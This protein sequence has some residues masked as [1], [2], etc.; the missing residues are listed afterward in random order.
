MTLDDF[1][2]IAIIPAV[3]CI[4]FDLSLTYHQRK[5]MFCIIQELLKKTY[6]VLIDENRFSHSDSDFRIVARNCIRW[7][8]VG[9]DTKLIMWMSTADISDAIHNELYSFESFLQIKTNSSNRGV[10]NSKKFSI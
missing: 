7:F 2:I 1:D 9:K 6:K 10:F 5:E 4:E 3:G 8:I